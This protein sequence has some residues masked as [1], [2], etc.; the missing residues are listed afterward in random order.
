MASR[1]RLWRLPHE[2]LASR[3]RSRL[4]SQDFGRREH[5][6][7]RAIEAARGRINAECRSIFILA[8]PAPIEADAVVAS[9]SLALAVET[10]GF[11]FPTIRPSVGAVQFEHISG[12][13]FHFPGF[14][15]PNDKSAQLRIPHHGNAPYQQPVRLLFFGSGAPSLLGRGIL[16][17]SELAEAWIEG[18]S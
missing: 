12:A 8:P 2:C 1:L 15:R 9:L 11:L 4:A 6:R 3:R 13:P 5:N 18:G 14:A 17:D 7:R 10:S 16:F